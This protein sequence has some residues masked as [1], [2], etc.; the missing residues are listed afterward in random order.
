MKLYLIKREECGYDEA[1]GFVVAAENEAEARKLASI[2][3][4]DEGKHCWLDE[5]ESECTLISNKT[6][7]KSGVVLRDF[8]D[9]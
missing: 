5:K 9:S 3:S 6:N 8:H 2:E 1:R 4:G 7:L